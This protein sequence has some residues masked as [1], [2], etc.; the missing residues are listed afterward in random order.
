MINIQKEKKLIKSTSIAVL[1]RPISVVISLIYT[2][3]LLNYLGDEQYGLWATLLSV[4]NWFTI[5]D[6]GI[7][8]G[9]RNVLSVEVANNDINR[10]KRVTSTAYMLICTVVS[11]LFCIMLVVVNIVNLHKVFNTSIEMKMAVIFIFSFIC[12]NFIF[13]L[14][15]AIFYAKQH[16]EIVPLISVCVQLM[17][18]VAIF[19][20]ANIL[21]HPENRIVYVSLTY[22][23]TIILVNTIFL[24]FL[25]MKGPYFIPRIRFFDKEYI[26][27]IFSFGIKLF[28]LQ[29]SAIILFT[30]DNM[31][32]TQLFSP[33]SVTTYSITRTIFNIIT[34]VFSAMLM[35]TCSRYTVEDAARNYTWIKKCLKIQM[36]LWGGGALGVLVLIIIF[37]PITTL[38]LGRDLGASELFISIMGILVISEMFTAIYSNF[39][40][41]I[42][43]INKQLTISII[44]AILN[45]PLSIYLAKY[46]GM[47]I[48]GICLGTLLCQ[49]LGCVFLPLDTITYIRTQEK[50]NQS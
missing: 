41:G 18:C 23:I 46:L 44:G 43:H 40:V 47:G 35:P 33:V 15:N 3:M 20:L 1:L 27:S 11:A 45:I 10:I 39:L 9:F 50:S 19:I 24:V 14:S 28:F 17:N 49:I 12:F 4:M 29:I 22:L 7:A 36:L 30:T 6:F 16:A 38:W 42:G 13:G 34:S 31:I 5:F 37:R 8:G 21:R 32:I 2:P 26:H 25:W 48:S